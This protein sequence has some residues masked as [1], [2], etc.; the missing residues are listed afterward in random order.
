MDMEGVGVESLL[1]ALDDPDPEVL[2]GA[3]P[4]HWPTCR[5]TGWR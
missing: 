2:A 3:R 5:R 4:A 1:R